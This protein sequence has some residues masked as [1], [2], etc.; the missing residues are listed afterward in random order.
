M[1]S[2]AQGAANAATARE[3][4][5]ASQS[6]LADVPTKPPRGAPRRATPPPQSAPLMTVI[7]VAELLGISTPYVYRLVHE[8]RIPHLK[9][10]HYVRFDPADLH[11]WLNEAKV[12]PTNS[13]GTR[14]SA[15]WRADGAATLPH[16]R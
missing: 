12:R 2:R 7:Q 16:R 5:P 11:R 1:M 8:R 4:T 6:P 15:N 10:G 13:P 3:S 14:P 9:F